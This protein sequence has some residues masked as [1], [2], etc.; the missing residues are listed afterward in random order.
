MFGHSA[1]DTTRTGFSAE[2]RKAT[3]SPAHTRVFRATS[4]GTIETRQK[5]GSD[6]DCSVSAWSEWTLSGDGCEETRF[7]TIVNQPACN[8]NPCPELEEHR[9][10]APTDAVWKWGAWHDDPNDPCQEIRVRVLVSAATCGGNPNDP[11][12]DG[13]DGSDNAPDPEPQPEPVPE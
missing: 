2:A 1:W 5:P 6:V 3:H 7:R 12:Y 9:P 8:G 11:P 13:S 10:V 4:E